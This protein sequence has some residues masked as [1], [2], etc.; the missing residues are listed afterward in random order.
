MLDTSVPENS[1]RKQI[2]TVAVVHIAFLAIT[3]TAIVFRASPF[4]SL[5][6]AGAFLTT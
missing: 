2:Q 5:S 6:S 1:L 3:I 4:G